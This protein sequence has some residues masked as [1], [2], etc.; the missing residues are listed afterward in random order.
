MTLPQCVSVL[1]ERRGLERLQA[2]IVK[3][4][5]PSFE[6]RCALTAIDDRLRWIRYCASL[7]DPGLIERAAEILNA[8]PEPA[9]A[10]T[11]EDWM[12]AWDGPD[13]VP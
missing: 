12:R 7:E 6:W 9:S 8:E 5:A 3:Q 1:R 10:F 13:Q 2:S 11:S 4:P